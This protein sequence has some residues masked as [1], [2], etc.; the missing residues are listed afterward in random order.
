M[1]RCASQR[2]SPY[3]VLRSF[4]ESIL[5]T[6]P[7]TRSPPS[8]SPSAMRRPNP[9]FT[10]VINHVLCAIASFLSVGESLSILPR[11]RT[12]ISE[13]YVGQ[14]SLRVYVGRDAD[15]APGIRL[16]RSRF[17]G[18]FCIFDTIRSYKKWGRG[19]TSASGPYDQLC[20]FVCLRPLA[21]PP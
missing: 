6:V 4:I 14:C 1:S 20:H 3:L 2:R 7:A 5:R 10:P 16:G 15:F 13:S 17:I 8:S 18:L 9:L 11:I 19:G 21:S 12:V